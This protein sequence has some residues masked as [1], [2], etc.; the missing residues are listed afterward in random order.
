MAEDEVFSKGKC[1]WQG[2]QAQFA[3]NAAAHTIL[4]VND[5]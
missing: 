4:K 3:T 1:T 2:T 5:P